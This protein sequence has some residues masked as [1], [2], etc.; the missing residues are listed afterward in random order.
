MRGAER[1][2]VLAF[3]GI[4]Y[5]APPVGPPALP[6]ARAARAVGRACATRRA[7]GPARRSAARCAAASSRASR[8][9]W[10]PAEDCLTLDVLTPGADGARRPV[11]VWLHGG[12]FVIGAGS[13]LVYGGERLARRGDV[14]VVT[15]NY[16]LGALGFLSLGDVAPGAGFAANLGL[17]DQIAALAWVQANIAALRR[18]PGQR[19]RV[20]RVARA[21]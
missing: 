10:R 12:A 16:R 3:R 17:R 7:S 18:R 19:H 9:P 8:A 11:L 1:R 4:P 13:A 20:R 2:G 15:L 5:A 14:V 21:R 6:P